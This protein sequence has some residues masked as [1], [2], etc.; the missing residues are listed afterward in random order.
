MYTIQ[1]ILY[2]ILFQLV[3][4]DHPLS[5]GTVYMRY[6]YKVYIIHCPLST[7]KSAVYIYTMY[8]IHC[9]LYSA[10]FQLVNIQCILDIDI[11]CILYILL[12]QLV[13][14]QY[15]E[16]STE[17]FTEYHTVYIISTVYIIDRPL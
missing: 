9:I 4:I 5:T 2:T 10:L 17:I 13:N 15:T 16:I 12:F 14:M 8:T 11:K 6:R 3:N 7:G 1:C